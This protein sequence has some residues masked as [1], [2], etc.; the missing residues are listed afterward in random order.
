MIRLMTSVMLLLTVVQLPAQHAPQPLRPVRDERAALPPDAPR[1]RLFPEGSTLVNREGRVI[2][3]DGDFVFQPLGRQES[4]PQLHIMP[5]LQLMG[6][7]RVLEE[8]PDARLRVTGTITQYRGRNYLLIDR[9]EQLLP[10]AQGTADTPQPAAAPSPDAGSDNPQSPVQESEVSIQR[11]H[12]ADK[13]HRRIRS[14][15]RSARC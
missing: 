11:A 5:S 14:R 6:I 15:L 2:Q 3:L 13:N 7:E 1:G 8:S 4:D 12:P 9:A 10:Q